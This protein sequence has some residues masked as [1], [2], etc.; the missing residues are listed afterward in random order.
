MFWRISIAS[1]IL[2]LTTIYHLHAQS[3]FRQKVLPVQQDT[4]LIDTLSLLPGSVFIHTLTGDSIEVSSYTID[5]PK[6]LLIWIKRPDLTQIHI[7]YR[8]LSVLFTRKYFNKDPRLIEQEAINNDA[9]I[10]Q[11]PKEDNTL[12]SLSGLNKSG[13]ISRSIGF[14]NNQDLSVNSDLSLQL[15]GKLSND[16]E[17]SAAISDDNIP[18]QPDGT[19]QQ[20]N[21]FDKVFIQFKRKNTSL[22]AGDYELRRPDSYF[23]N[24]FKRTQGGSFSTSFTNAKEWNYKSNIS[25]AVAKGRSARNLFNGIEAN[26]GPYRLTGNNGELYVIILSGT[27]RVYLDGQMLQRG[28]DNDYVIDY[29]T[30]EITFTPRRIITQNSRISA[31]FEYS[32]KNY[33]RT[34]TYFNQEISNKKI[35]FK[36]NFYNEQDNRNQ[37]FLQNLNDTQKQF[38]KGIGND[39]SLA[40]YPNVEAVAFSN[41]EILYKQI[42]TLGN[43]GVYVYSTNPNLARYRLGFSFVGQGSG[44]YK[45]NN[46]SAANGRVFE[47]IAPS[48]GIKQG[49]YEPITLL[50]TPKKQQLIT[51]GVDYRLSKKT[52]I[53]NEIGFSNND[54]NLFSDIGNPDNKGLAYKLKASNEYHL[55]H[56]D[57]I[58]LKLVT[59]LNYEFAG[60]HFKAV[61]RYRSVEFQRDF[62]LFGQTQ[63]SNEHLGGLS[64]GLIRDALNQVT[65]HFN[66]F[67]RQGNYNGFQ[68]AVTGNYQWKNNQISYSGNYLTA[69]AS[70]NKSSFLR[71]NAGISR[72]FWKLISGIALEKELNRTIDKQNNQ[73][74]LASFAFTQLKFY[75]NSDVSKD[76]RFKA[77]YSK[78]Y[79]KLPF[80]NELK[81]SSVADMVML[82]LDFTKNPNS[83]LNISSTYRQVDY[84]QHI[85]KQNENT[86]LGRIEH[87]LNL[88]KGFINA[89]TYY[90]LGTG[91]E[92]KREFTYLEVQAGQG[93]YAWNDY[94]GNGIKEL[95][96][97]EL[98][99]FQDQ[100]TFIRIF[101]P[102]N[103]FI[104][105]NYTA[106]NQTLR[107]SPASVLKNKSNWLSK[108]SGQSSFK[109]ERK[110]LDQ[111]GL[112]GF[113][114]FDV[115]ID[116][117]NL[118]SLNS[119]FR[120]TLFFNRNNPIYS[121]D[122]NYQNT[123]GKILLSNG[124]DTRK[125]EES[126]VR[127]RWNI[128]QKTTIGLESK[129]GIKRFDSELFTRRNYR[130]KFLEFLPESN[131]QF[132]TNFRLTFSGGYITQQNEKSLGGEKTANTR[133]TTEASY[134]I[135]KKGLI[136]SRVNFIK[137]DFSGQSNSPIAYEL[138][139]GLQPGNNI[140]WSIGLQRSVANGIQ[141]NVN[142]EGRKSPGVRSIHTGGVQVRAFF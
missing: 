16:I 7:T 32:D 117:A 125:R 69:D 14:G 10:Y 132:S 94:N 118:V 31:E 67:I 34:L 55:S 59:S 82:G 74:N 101:R 68:Q 133:F 58:G 28:Q 4:L 130:I 42:D 106:I 109:I 1:L 77:E 100:A 44:N 83:V 134:A 116:A 8:V 93:A 71:Q 30:A 24:F 35:A 51:L 86:L 126:G 135:L 128:L 81:S 107:F 139:D 27:E 142:Y 115:R 78:R 138:L 113:N 98:S 108:F 45:L 5:Y 97:F 53:S 36:L 73:L 56:K 60:E 37:P 75:V 29:N 43:V 19:T 136:T 119:F 129:Q 41:N 88:W 11:V 65:Y 89:N 120:N 80:G 90:E 99:R 25:A 12:F 122:L 3:S 85:A 104:Q 62:N 76:N 96:E 111:T 95:N 2:C 87:N 141:L 23:M 121:I 102:G 66:T 52:L 26:Q 103:E 124:F 33:A 39:I 137:N 84:S 114:P 110:I 91:Q 48:N 49:N 17:I 21:D 64:I 54:V 46:T 6:S 18:I 50:V 79:D 72:K 140:T 47:F 20:I 9:F 105:T 61:E 123:G 92:P 38:L 70:L 63:R 57:T 112:S 131:Y 40:F 22:I 13:S 127:L 15:A